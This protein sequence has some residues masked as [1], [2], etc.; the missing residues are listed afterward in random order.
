MYVRGQ[1]SHTGDSVNLLIP[2]KSSANPSHDQASY[3]IADFKMGLIS[4]DGTWQFDFFVNNVTDERAELYHWTGNYEWASSHSTEYE[5]YHR[6]YTNRP[7]EWGVRYTH[8][9]GD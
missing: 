7:R 1:F 2:E 4:Q 8:R 5:H 3:S 9:W 6:I